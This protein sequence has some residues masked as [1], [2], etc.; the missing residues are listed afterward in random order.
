MHNVR[1]FTMEQST[2]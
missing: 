2:S 1:L